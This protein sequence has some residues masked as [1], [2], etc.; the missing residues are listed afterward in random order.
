MAEFPDDPKIRPALIVSVD[1]R[2]QYS[3]NVLAIPLTTN[4]KPG[5]THVFLPRGQG[6]IITDSMART[7]A[8]SLILECTA[9]GFQG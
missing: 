5:Q 6:G 7:S 8:M 4:L 2:N 1:G 9:G 3:N